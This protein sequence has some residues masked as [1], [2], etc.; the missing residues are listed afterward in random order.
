MQST[1]SSVENTDKPNQESDVYSRLDDITQ[2]D[3]P[4]QVEVLQS[5]LQQ[6]RT[7]LDMQV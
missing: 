6:L 1:E 4:E 2:L 7:D 3:L 5:V